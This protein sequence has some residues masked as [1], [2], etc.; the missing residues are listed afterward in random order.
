MESQIS[1]LS[2]TVMS[3]LA[4]DI[5]RRR[6]GIINNNLANILNNLNDL[7][8]TMSITS[9]STYIDTSNI[10]TYMKD[11]F[12]VLTLNIQSLHAKFDKLAQFI[13]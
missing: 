4:D 11:S 10:N 13:Q 8:T 9:T 6:G 5:L 7:E 2:T 1:Y 3:N 12:T